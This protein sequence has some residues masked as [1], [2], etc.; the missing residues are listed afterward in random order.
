MEVTL[1]KVKTFTGT[2]GYGLNAD[3]Y[4]DGVKCFFF[5]DDA[6]GGESVH[7]SYDKEL[8]KKLEEYVKTLPPDTYTLDGETHTMPASIDDLV[9]KAHEQLELEKSNKR[10]MKKTEDKIIVVSGDG[11]YAYAEFNGANIRYLGIHYPNRIKL[12]LESLS[13][14]YPGWKLLNTNIPAELLK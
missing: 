13:K 6:G 5:I 14:K 2:D 11:R 9:N 4:V 12:A 7:H 1:K 3:V 10:L 8:Y